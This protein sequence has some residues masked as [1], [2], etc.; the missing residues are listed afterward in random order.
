MDK[1]VCER[2]IRALSRA[3]LNG[4]ADIAGVELAR[5]ITRISPHEPASVAFGAYL[6]A[7]AIH[8]S[9]TCLRLD[10]APDL[11]ENMQELVASCGL[12]VERVVKDIENSETVGREG[13]S[14]P[15][16]LHDNRLYLH[17]YWSYEKALSELIIKKA[18]GGPEDLGA[19][20][21][22]Q[23]V[24]VVQRLFPAKA[25]EA[26]DWQ[27]LA[28]LRALF[29]DILIISGGPGTGKTRTVTAI[30]AALI[31][32]DPK[33]D[34]SIVMC[35]PT[36]K[37]AARLTESVASASRSFNLSEGIL[38]KMPK[39]ASTIHRL[40]GA[41]PVTGGFRHNRE[42]PLPYKVVIVDEASMVDL[43][44]MAHLVDALAPDTKLILLG[45]RDQLASVE[46]GSVLGDICMG[47]RL[48]SY[49]KSFVKIA[50]QAD[51]H[52]S[53]EQEKGTHPLRDSIIT[54]KHNYRFNGESGI[55]ELALAVRE[56]DYKAVKEILLS[57]EKGRVNFIPSMEKGLSRLVEH[58]AGSFINSV[59]AAKSPAE[60]IKRMEG[61]KIL[62]GIKRGGAG[63]EDINNYVAARFFRTRGMNMVYRGMPVIINRNDYRLELFNGDTG[64]I[65][66]GAGGGLKAWFRFGGDD[67]RAFSISRLPPFEPAW[68]VTVH[69]SQGSEFMKAIVM[70][71]YEKGRM[72]GRELLYTAITRAREE[73]TVW[74]GWEDLRACVETPTRRD[75]GL[76]GMLWG[77]MSEKM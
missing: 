55:D 44:M 12:D 68:A 24:K 70:L 25:P 71:P 45:D 37:A 51:E 17:R 11:T 20:Y 69:R 5:F 15:L 27:K 63:V 73:V 61:V 7:A 75:S 6:A 66:P 31:E 22:E 64:I 43:S 74:G 47:E 48:F 58:E 54:L 4:D 18:Q 67:L 38:E 33:S 40:L 46:A 2:L 53:D 56:G 1:K 23:A 28:T 19:G 16:L 39:K 42:N 57:K 29:T 52:V 21:R 65:W 26:P 41:V 60:A 59:Y 30:M 8:D 3:A 72:P 77:K 35:A 10:R 50:E 76:G 36:G 14:L 34:I 49:S 9:H 13:D 32:T 62:C